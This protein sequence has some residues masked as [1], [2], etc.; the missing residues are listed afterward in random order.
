MTFVELCI[1]LS[2]KY[3][4]K[5]P[6]SFAYQTMNLCPLISTDQRSAMQPSQVS[7]HL[8]IPL[9]IQLLDRLPPD[10]PIY[11]P[12]LIGSLPR[13]AHRPLSHGNYTAKVHSFLRLPRQ[14]NSRGLGLPN[15]VMADNGPIGGGSP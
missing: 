8:Y 11:I 6:F 4:R 12:Q 7:F 2:L 9:S 14:M 3:S 10:R 13:T 15:D 1:T 5:A